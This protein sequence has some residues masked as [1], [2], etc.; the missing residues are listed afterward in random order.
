MKGGEERGGEGIGRERKGGEER[1]GERRG[2][3]GG[4]EKRG[5]GRE[6]RGGEGRRGE[7]G[8]EGRGGEGRGG[9]VCTHVRISQR[10]GEGWK[11][12]DGGGVMHELSSLMIRSTHF[13]FGNR[14]DTI[15]LN[16]LR[17][18]WRNFGTLTSLTALRQISSSSMSGFSRLRLPAAE[19]TVLTARIPEGQEGR[20][21][22]HVTT[23]YKALLIQSHPTLSP[24]SQIIHIR[25]YSYQTITHTHPYTGVFTDTSFMPTSLHTPHTSPHYTTQPHD[26]TS[27]YPYRVHHLQVLALS[28]PR[29]TS[30]T[31]QSRS[32]PVS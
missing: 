15:P 3:E 17:S 31:H 1:G 9:E 13:I 26:H 7:R 22:C 12:K 28:L 4:K 6:G 30:N 32:G 21:G 27:D 18:S 19:I 5:E 20:K 10:R 2:R 29:I 23:G 24:L 8:G 16:S 25:S 14:S 11:D